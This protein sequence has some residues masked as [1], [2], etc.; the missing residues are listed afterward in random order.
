MTSNS[1]I[2]ELKEL[3]NQT[4]EKLY[5]NDMSL[6][7][8]EANERAITSRFAR[9]LEDLVKTSSFEG[10]D[11]DVE[12][13]RNGNEPKRTNSSPL[14]TYPDVLLHKREFNDNNKLVV[15]FKCYWSQV[16]DVADRKKLI[17]FTSSSDRYQYRLGAFVY[18]QRGD[19]K[20]TYFVNGRPESIVQKGAGV[21]SS[22]W[23][24]FKLGEIG[25]VVTG[26]TP[27]TSN[28][29]NFGGTVP[30]VTP[31]DMD[32]RKKI[33]STA[34][35]LT[36]SGV[37]SVKNS[38]I[39]A[40]SIMVSCIGSDM[41]KSVIAGKDCVTNQQIN[42]IVVKQEFQN[43]F[44]Y[45]NLSMR[46][47][48]L[49]NLASS[50]ST[51]PILN[52]SGFSEIEIKIPPFATQREISSILGA[53]DD[54]ITLLR[55][56]N[57]TLEAIAQALFKSW[58]VDFDPVHAKQQGSL[59]EGMDEQTAALFPDS[60]EE[61][62]LGLVPAG[63]EVGTLGDILTLRN[64]RTKPTEKTKTLPY[65]PTESISAKIP[66]LQEYKSG[67]EANSSLILFHEGDILFGAM[68][69]Y[70]HKVCIAP[71]DG[72]TRTTVFTLVAKPNIKE[73]ALFQ[74]YQET[75]IEYATQ[76][77]EGS[78]IPYAKWDKS[79]EKMQIALPPV[80]LQETFSQAVSSFV[81]KANTNV[82]MIQT[83][84]DLRD[85][86]LPRLISGQ[87]RV[88]DVED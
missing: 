42:S 71:F 39:P 17:D 46:K 59:P 18:L 40:G 13:N 1:E 28:L 80:E 45:Y 64:E 76:H 35:Y 69:P 68:R 79:L 54:R 72:V 77:S 65:V 12:Y 81:Q 11:V 61:S 4:L 41:G 7:Q 47:D 26:K 63:W 22:E 84:A 56:T 85:T 19:F 5:K 44:I 43:E 27:K 29:D 52:K 87:L 53:L 62:E 3:L 75:T 33:S 25:K 6:I 55:E 9:Y 70:F 50:G 67:E 36:E 49:R 51:M 48:E 73:F 86:L 66:F 23:K 20:V 10:L 88:G 83:L 82:Q 21:T 2:V 57:A 58:F 31:T 78:T 30:F 32:G 14:G 16:D 15:E 38:F 8:R 34:R 37:L 24:T 60:F 74:M